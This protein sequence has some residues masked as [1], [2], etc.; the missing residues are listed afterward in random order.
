MLGMLLNKWVGVGRFGLRKGGKKVGVELR[1]EVVGGKIAAAL[2]GDEVG[3][4]CTT[5]HLLRTY[6]Y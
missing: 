5:T 3:N 6:T 2:G 4:D 1:P